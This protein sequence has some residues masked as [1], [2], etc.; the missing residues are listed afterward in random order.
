[1]PM[2]EY[3]LSDYLIFFIHGFRKENQKQLTIQFVR[4]SLYSLYSIGTI[5]TGI[6]DFFTI[7]PDTLP[8]NAL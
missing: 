4:Q 8:T 2:Y 5:S 6:F 1:M 7:F 3:I